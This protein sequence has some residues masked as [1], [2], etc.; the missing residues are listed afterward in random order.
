MSK[1]VIG[2]KKSLKNILLNKN[3]IFTITF[4]LVVLIFFH[5]CSIL[6]IPGVSVPEGGISTSDFT[7]ML[8]LLAGGGLSKMSLFSIGV[9]PYITAQIIIQLLSSDL[10]PPLSK[11]AKSGERG[12]K[13]L[14][15]ITRIV[16]LPFCVAQAYA[17]IALLLQSGNGEITIFGKKT[18]A[19]L[20][21]G[22]ITG[23][24][25]IFTAGT[26]LA[27]FLGDMI[28]KR[29]VGNGVTLLILS[30]I[31]ASIF[32]NFTVAFKTIISQVNSNDAKNI[33]LMVL[34][35]AMYVIVFLVLLIFVIFIN[36]SLRKIPIQ[37]TGQGLITDIEKLPYLPIK[38]N[39]AG[40]IPVIFASS[41]MTIPVTIAQF[42]SNDNE[43]KWFINEYLPVEK[44]LGL[45]LYFI[46]IILF[47]FFYS[48]IQINPENLAENFEKSGKFIPGVKTGKDTEKHIAKVLNRVNWIGAPFLAVVASL[49]YIISMVTQIPSGLALGGTGIIIIVTGTMELW[50]SI[51]SNSTTSGYNANRAKIESRLQKSGVAQVEKTDEDKSYRMW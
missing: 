7:S 20:S 32:S 12:K 44:P 4:T 13:K 50:N 21:A 36:D 35:I 3:V 16:C 24:I 37:Q 15:I 5:V 28:T 47:S 11:M 19:D 18:L 6:P 40:V 43:G 51:K 14:E 33:V 38:L 8:N 26:Y 9:G 1:S 46:F 45:S 29:G 31:V 22:E 34:S 42:L 30:G 25:A 41:L 27:I 48:Y 23:L 2:N 17:V 10:I 49:P 39:A